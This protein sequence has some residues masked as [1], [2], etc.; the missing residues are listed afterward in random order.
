MAGSLWLEV[1]SPRR[2]KVTL[3]N[4]EFSTGKQMISSSRQMVHFGKLGYVFEFINIEEAIYQRN[5]RL[6]FQ[7]YLQKEPP[8]TDMSATPSPWD[9]TLGDWQIKGT[10]G[11]GAFGTVQAAQNR[12]TGVL[13]AAKFMI[14]NTIT[15]PRMAREIDLLDQIP[16]H[17][18]MP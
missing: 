1:L 12:I 7:N 2:P 6:F 11:K 8:P 17:V 14:R 4:T 13:G 3:G 9:L 16:D 15:W 5:L 18:C 10:V